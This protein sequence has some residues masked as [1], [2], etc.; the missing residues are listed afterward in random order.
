MAPRSE[1]RLDTIPPEKKPGNQS[2]RK[3]CTYVNRRER[4]I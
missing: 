2:A 3:K 4:G 1:E